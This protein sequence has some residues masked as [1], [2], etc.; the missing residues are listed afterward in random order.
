MSE[1]NRNTTL[2][3]VY[4][5][6]PYHASSLGHDAFQKLFH[7]MSAT[8]YTS[9]W[10]L[11]HYA[12]D[13]G[14]EKIYLKDI[15]QQMDLPMPKVSKLVKD[16]KSKGFVHWTHDGAGED[17]TY[18]QFTDSFLDSAQEQKQRLSNYYTRVIEAFGE[19]SFLHLLADLAKLEEIMR[20]EAEKAGEVNE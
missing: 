11:Y 5:S 14:A 12:Q 18:I 6:D 15:A 13:T 7:K 8:E 19:E 17:G 10:L 2:A 20:L 9:M 3:A 16:L 1:N 4:G